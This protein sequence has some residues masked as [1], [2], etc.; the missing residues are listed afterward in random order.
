MA[1]FVLCA[2]TVAREGA[3]CCA[4]ALVLSVVNLLEGTHGGQSDDKVDLRTQ[5]ELLGTCNE[6]FP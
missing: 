2:R 1:N 3:G 5:T 4:G 6:A